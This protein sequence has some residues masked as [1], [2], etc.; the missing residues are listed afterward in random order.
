MRTYDTQQRALVHGAFLV[1]N[2]QR[3]RDFC[4]RIP[5]DDSQWSLCNI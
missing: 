4:W 2:I 3:C 5:T 1:V